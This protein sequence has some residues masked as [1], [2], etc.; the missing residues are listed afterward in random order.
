MYIEFSKK[1]GHTAIYDR[2]HV[3]SHSRRKD[4]AKSGRSL[5]NI[6]CN[7]E[8][9]TP[10][11]PNKQGSASLAPRSP[12]GQAVTLSGANISGFATD[13]TDTRGPKAKLVL[14]MR[15]TIICELVSCLGGLLGRRGERCDVKPWY[16]DRSWY[17]GMSL[18]HAPRLTRSSP[19]HEGVANEDRGP[20]KETLPV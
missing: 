4:S 6:A 19:P 11:H 3:V 10:R 14:C 5:H 8:G 13:G 16:G 1:E 9:Q 17:K 7:G 20:W 12:N 15:P 2:K 18:P